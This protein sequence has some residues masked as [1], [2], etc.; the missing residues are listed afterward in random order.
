MYSGDEFFRKQ[1]CLTKS[2]S[3]PLESPA[4]RQGLAGP[5]G[6]WDGSFGQGWSSQLCLIPLCPR[7]GHRACPRPAAPRLSSALRETST[8]IPSPALFFCQ[9]FLLCER[10]KENKHLHLPS[11][12][13]QPICM[14]FLLWKG[15][16][17][18]KK[19]KSPACQLIGANDVYTDIP[20]WW[21][22]PNIPFWGEGG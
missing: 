17:C 13:I 7:R 19:W 14:V 20:Q 15:A 9:G 4:E 21:N 22:S 5:A 10:S 1:P 6:V 12:H 11:E 2:I 8:L 3:A 18:K 16:I